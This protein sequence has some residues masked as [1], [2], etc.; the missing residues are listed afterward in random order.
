MQQ[1]VQQR[2]VPP[3]R[4]PPPNFGA[5]AASPRPGPTVAIPV[6]PAVPE[7]PASPVGSAYSPTDTPT[8]RIT[9]SPP[10][11][12]PNRLACDRS[13][14]VAR[15]DHQFAL[16][17]KCP[18]NRPARPPM[19]FS[20]A[21]PPLQPAPEAHRE[22]VRRRAPSPPRP[23][24]RGRPY[25]RPTIPSKDSAFGRPSL[26]FARA[27]NL[28]AD[29]VPNIQSPPSPPPMVRTFPGPPQAPRTPSPPLA[30]IPPSRTQSPDIFLELYQHSRHPVDDRSHLTIIPSWA[31]KAEKEEKGECVVCYGEQEHLQVRCQN[32]GTM[33]VCC[34]CIVGI[35]QSIN[36]CPVCRFRGEF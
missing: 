23:V 22:R 18:D 13:Y 16:P 2:L 12:S 15:Q 10:P 25:V 21:N 11:Y 33:R 27:R 34:I 6:S 14:Y 19:P 20:A 3:P 32:C 5:S 29:F 36:S 30:E 7:S 24:G 4:P 31:I 17:A 35:Y 9:P 28:F 26:P 8:K 1:S